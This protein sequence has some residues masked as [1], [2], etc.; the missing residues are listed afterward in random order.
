MSRE[1][2]MDRDELVARWL[3]ERYGAWLRVSWSGGFD[4][5]VPWATEETRQEWLAEAAELQEMLEA[6]A[7]T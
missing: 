1:L 5:D 6:E 7:G 4:P 2:I 3:Y